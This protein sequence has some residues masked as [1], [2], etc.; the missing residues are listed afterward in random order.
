MSEIRSTT[1]LVEN[2]MHYNGICVYQIR[3][4]ICYIKQHT[5]CITYSYLTLILFSLKFRFF[6]MLGPNSNLALFHPLL[7]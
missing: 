2:E 1:C 3:C 5:S 7:Y 4:Y 6:I